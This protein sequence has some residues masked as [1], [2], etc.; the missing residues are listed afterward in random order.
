MRLYWRSAFDGSLASPARYLADDS[1]IATPTIHPSSTE[2]TTCGGV[3]ARRYSWQLGSWQEWRRG[4]ACDAARRC[5][6]GRAPIR[7]RSA[8]FC[9]SRPLPPQ[10]IC[11]T[12]AA[13][14]PEVPA[15][16]KGR[17][18]RSGEG[19]FNTSGVRE[20]VRQPKTATRAD[21][22]GGWGLRR[23]GLTPRYASG[24]NQLAAFAFATIMSV[25][26]SSTLTP[27]S[28]GSTWARLPLP[29]LPVGAAELCAACC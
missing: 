4:G 13:Q 15:A 18:R 20:G 26:I 17:E 29:L 24:P 23:G 9:S 10:S 14:N 22:T 28:E 19:R 2:V 7:W 16:S 27:P 12:A 5:R 21:G 8:F 11:G 3:G 25:P 6:A 1:T